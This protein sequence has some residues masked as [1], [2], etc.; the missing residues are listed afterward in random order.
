MW[1]SGLLVLAA[2][3]GVRQPQRR[4]NKTQKK[5][6]LETSF[7]F[8]NTIFRKSFTFRKVS[9][10]FIFSSAAPFPHK[11]EFQ[12][13][14]TFPSPKYVTLTPSL[15]KTDVRGK[16]PERKQTISDQP[17]TSGSF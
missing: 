1:D 10:P 3:S 9:F 5:Y 7:M 4:K 14:S 6:S 13:M 8:G 16:F 11:A 17:Q 15:R 12:L 2:V